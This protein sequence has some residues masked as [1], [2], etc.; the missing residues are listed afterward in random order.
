MKINRLLPVLLL[1]F[2]DAFGFTIMIPVLPF[3]VEKYGYGDI[4]YGLLLSTYAFFQFIAAPFLGT[5]SDKYGRKPILII[6]QIGTFLSWIIFAIAYFT[7]EINI[8]GISLPILIIFLSRIIDGM[9]GGNVSVVMAYV[10]DIT[11]EEKRAQTFGIVSAMGGIAMILGPVIGSLSVGT[12][13]EYLGAIIIAGT[14]SLFTLFSVMRIKESLP[15]NKRRA[16]KLWTCWTELLIWKKILKFRGFTEI[17]KLFNIKVYF[18]FALNSFTTVIILFLIDDFGYSEKQLGLV[19]FLVGIMMVINQLVLVKLF[20]TRFGEQ[21]SL[22]IALFCMASGLMV[23]IFFDNIYLLLACY[24]LMSIGI[25]VGFS[26]FAALLT[27][28][29]PAEQQGEILGID[30]SIMAFT[31]GIAPV[32]ASLIY[33]GIGQLV[34]ALLG[35]IVLIGPALNRLLLKNSIVKV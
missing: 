24:Y 32:L 34:F 11:A 15:E 12:K 17:L 23:S 3:I 7:P 4:M 30:T 14:I 20:V 5:L 29:S 8:I 1:S 10:A 25:S 31:S 19:L 13:V 6:S 21:R 18:S 22:I 27:K 33:V 16:R 35:V 28:K 2:V 26:T 9:T